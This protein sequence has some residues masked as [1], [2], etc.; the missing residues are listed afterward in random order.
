MTPIV[1]NG[2]NSCLLSCSFFRCPVDNA[3]YELGWSI[4]TD[5]RK[6][7]RKCWALF[8]RFAST[9]I[10]II[11]IHLKQK[12]QQTVRAGSKLAWC[13]NV[14]YLNNLNTNAHSLQKK[15][16]ADFYFFVSVPFI[17]LWQNVSVHSFSLFFFSIRSIRLVVIRL[18]DDT[19]L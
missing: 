12:P 2:I 14:F 8:A 16:E 18:L 15:N 4:L 19:L 6:M 3:Y 7:L 1:A 5:T 11:I 17:C 13:R 9:D 10:I